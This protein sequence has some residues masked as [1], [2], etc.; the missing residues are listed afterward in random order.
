M[1]S[2]DHGGDRRDLMRV[3]R[4]DNVTLSHGRDNLTTDAVVT[5]A[6]TP[7][8]NVEA[9]DPM[10]AGRDRGTKRSSRYDAG[11]DRQPQPTLECGVH[12]ARARWLAE[13]SRYDGWK[14]SG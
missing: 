14:S 3:R 1:H 10:R 4:H 7:A 11:G 12:G 13:G 9:I 2:G 8:G 6:L 5:L